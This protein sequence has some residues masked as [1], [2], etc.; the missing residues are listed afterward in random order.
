M[1]GGD[2]YVTEVD[3]HEPRTLV[4]GYVQDEVRVFPWLIVNGGLRVDRHP[5]FGTH[6]APRLAAVVLPRPQTS[7]KVLSGHAY[8]APNTYES[9][10]Y[11]AGPALG[12]TLV[13]EEMQ[14]TEAVWEEYISS[15]VRTSVTIFTY[16]VDR[17]VEQRSQGLESGDDLYFAN[18][19]VVEGNGFEAEVE[20][21]LPRGISASFGHTF[22]KVRD[23]VNDHVFSNSPRHLSKLGVQI[24]IASFYVGVQGQ[25]IGRRLSVGG[26]EVDGA[27]VPNVT[28]TSPTRRNVDFSISINNAFNTSYADPGAEEHLQQSIPQDGRTLLARVRVKF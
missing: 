4:A 12:F 18:G 2:K 10:Y 1:I 8:R 22:A 25:Y 16:R 13:P 15:R 3:V 23:V 6:V 26:Q 17:L 9:F 27:F 14:S 7:I 19:G 24:P 11:A 20:A 5:S 28:L 21:K